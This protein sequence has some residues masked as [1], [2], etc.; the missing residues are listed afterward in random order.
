MQ[1]VQSSKMLRDVYHNLQDII[2]SDDDAL[3]E[4]TLLFTTRV[5]NIYSDIII[6]LA[7]K[8][9]VQ[10]Y[11]DILKIFLQIKKDDRSYITS[12]QHIL[13]KEGLDSQEVSD[14][15]RVNR[16]IYNSSKSF[17]TAMRDLFL[18][19]EQ[20]RALEGAVDQEIQ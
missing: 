15:I 4:Q 1:L 7:V 3:E 17:M 6:L 10:T 14:L 12:V 9:P 16:Y 8:E 20:R 5:R 13:K 18:N 2:V 19:H 11:Q